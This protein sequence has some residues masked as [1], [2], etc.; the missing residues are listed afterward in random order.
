VEDGGPVPYDLV[1]GDAHG[2][3]YWDIVQGKVGRDTWDVRFVVG[4][5]KSIAYRQG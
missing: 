2:E 5:D 3:A 4:N 1:N